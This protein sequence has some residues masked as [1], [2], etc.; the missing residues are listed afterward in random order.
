MTA[1][2]PRI[3]RAT[4]PQILDRDWTQIQE[5]NVCLTRTPC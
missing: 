2:D 5:E 4:T 1:N 3:R